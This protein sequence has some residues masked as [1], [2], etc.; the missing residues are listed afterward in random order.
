MKRVARLMRET[1]IEG[2]S[3]R[4]RTRTTQR[5][6]G[7][8]P[9][10]DLVDPEFTAMGP[11][12]LWVPEITYIRT[13]AGFLCLAVIL[14]VWSRRIVGWAMATHRRTELVLD[15]LNMALW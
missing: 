5:Q 8:R 12:Q 10:P 3:W 11:D 13:W 14:D 15:A 2:V 6:Q 9:A 1:G 7:A 4:R